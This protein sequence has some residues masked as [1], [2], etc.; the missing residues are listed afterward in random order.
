MCHIFVKAQDCM[1][2]ADF[3]MVWLI[4]VYSFDKM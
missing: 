2:E 3:G 1:R 4:N